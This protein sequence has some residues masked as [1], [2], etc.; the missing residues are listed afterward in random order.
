AVDAIDGKAAPATSSEAPDRMKADL[1]TLPEYCGAVAQA[2]FVAG[3]PL[4]YP[5]PKEGERGAAGD[6]AAQMEQL[7]NILIYVA[8]MTGNARVDGVTLGVSD[9]VGENQGFLAMFVRGEWDADA[10]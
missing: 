8:E 10:V 4:V 9:E 5:K 7:T 6:T 1:Y 3:E 2:R